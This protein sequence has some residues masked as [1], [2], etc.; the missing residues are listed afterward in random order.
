MIA[1]NLLW[2][3]KFEYELSQAEIA[4]QNGNEGRSRVC[5]RRAAGVVV[6]AYLIQ[7]GYPNPGPSIQ[8]RIRFLLTLDNLSPEIHQVAGHFLVK[9][10]Q[11]Y[12]LP[13]QADLIADARWLVNQ[14]M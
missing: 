4:R 1:N 7:H 14:L 3:S 12:T 9:V 8:D 11:D 13:I 6:E 10:T 5:A 2:K